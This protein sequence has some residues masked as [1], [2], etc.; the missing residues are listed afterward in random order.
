MEL[1]A[2]SKARE[3]SLDDVDAERGRGW[4]VD[5]HAQKKALESPF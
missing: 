3:C 2:K 4:N 1:S 5:A